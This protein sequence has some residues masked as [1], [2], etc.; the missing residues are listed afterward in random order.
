MGKREYDEVARIYP[1]GI[2]SFFLLMKNNQSF[3]SLETFFPP[4]NCFI[5]L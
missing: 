5:Y 1:P 4:P 2:E 3:F